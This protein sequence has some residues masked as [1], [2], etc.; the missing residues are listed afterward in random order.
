MLCE[1]SAVASRADSAPIYEDEKMPSSE[2]ISNKATFKR[3][4]DANNTDDL[5]LVS[6]TIDQIVA[7]DVQFHAA[8]VMFYE[9]GMGVPTAHAFGHGPC[10]LKPISRGKLSLRSA[11]PFSKP[12]IMHNYFA[13]PE[14]RQSMID[15][16]R[17][18]LEIAAQPALR[19]HIK[20]PHLTPKSSS[21]SD[22]WEIS[23]RKPSPS[24]TRPAPA[25]SGRWW[26]ANSRCTGSTAYA[27]S[28][29]R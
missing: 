25:R 10:V 12:R 14:D 21:E 26:T 28:T 20:A 9:E 11:N 2:A 29:P 6:K 16:I 13:V 22:V 15:G 18:G 27:W 23:R 17:I 8:P 5:A 7:P 19:S 24:I 1:R 4:V 3:F